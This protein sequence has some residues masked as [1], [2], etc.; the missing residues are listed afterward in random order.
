[1]NKEG[2]NILGQTRI[3]TN[4]QITL[5]KS[6]RKILNATKGDIIIFSRN[7]ENINIKLIKIK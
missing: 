6:V 5:P 1:M 3:T 4:Y 7:G 2:Y